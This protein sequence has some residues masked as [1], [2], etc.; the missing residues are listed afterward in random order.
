VACGAGNDLVDAD[1]S[2]SVS[3]DCETVARQLSRDGV[4]GDD[5]QHQ[6]EVEPASAAS[7]GTVV[8][9]FQS[10]RFVGGG[11][12]GIGFAT[13][14]DAGKNWRSGLLPSLTVASTPAGSDLRASDPS[15]AHD[16]LHGIW[17]IASLGLA[18]GPWELAVSRSTDGLSWSPPVAAVTGPSESLDKE[19][20]TCDNWPSSPYHGRC[21]LSFLDVPTN[22][23]STSTSTDGGSTWGQPVPI[24]PSQSEINGAQ[25]VARPDGTLVVVYASL[26]KKVFEENEVLAAR[27]TDGGVTFS[28]PTR[29]ATLT[30][31]TV[32]GLRAPSL[33]AAGIDESGRLYTAWEDCR[34]SSGCTRNDLVLAR[35]EDGVTWSDPV[36]IPTTGVGADTDSV[37]CGLGVDPS[38]TGRL[39]LVYYTRHPDLALDVAMISSIDGGATW[40]TPTRLNA[41][42]MDLRWLAEAAGGAMVGDY[43]ALSYVRGR[44]VPVFSLASAPAPDGTFRQS[45]FARV[46]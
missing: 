33:P 12:T 6:T 25:P 1:L 39:A 8:T 17:L 18:A 15:V 21:Y 20:I 19:W 16:A 45:I 3:R 36:R 5:A 24:T 10:G 27:S 32:R 46:R 9:A 42:S 38:A 44:A 4:S 11:A 30:A 40:A 37:V 13:S 41:E 22:T 35:S 26:T 14:T 2:D 23:I 34:F 31:S 43:V 7:G 28:P 29:V